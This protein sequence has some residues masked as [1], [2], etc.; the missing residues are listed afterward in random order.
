[1]Q[2]GYDEFDIDVSLAYQGAIFAWPD[3]PPSPPDIVEEKGQREL[4]WFLVRHQ[5]DRAETVTDAGFAIIKL[6]FRH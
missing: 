2:A 6:H 4:A 3:R 1:L 5:A